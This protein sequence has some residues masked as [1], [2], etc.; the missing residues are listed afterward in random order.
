MST[1]LLTRAANNLVFIDTA[2][3]ALIHLCPDYLHDN[4][5]K[6]CVSFI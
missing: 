3:F 2:L 4:K 5:Q 1:C 6:M